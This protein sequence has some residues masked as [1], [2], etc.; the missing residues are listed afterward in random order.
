MPRA[1]TKRQ[2]RSLLAHIQFDVELVLDVCTPGQL[3]VNPDIVDGCPAGSTGC[4]QAVC[5]L[6]EA[7]PAGC[8]GSETCE[9]W[10]EE[11]N[12]PP[13]YEDVGVCALPV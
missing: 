11:G 4:C 6:S 10:F 12:V 3:P 1:V 5:D 13:G 9:P 7:M 8:T 2:L